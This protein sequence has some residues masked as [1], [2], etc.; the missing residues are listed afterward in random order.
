[1][2]I[3][4][5]HSNIHMIDLDDL[6]MKN[7]QCLIIMEAKVSETSWLSYYKLDHVSI[8]LQLNLRCLSI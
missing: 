7:S 2:F 6:F 1:M 3:G 8:D 5:R 4:H